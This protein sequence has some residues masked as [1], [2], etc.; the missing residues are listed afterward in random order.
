KEADVKKIFILFSLLLSAGITFAQ[1]DPGIH[2]DIQIQSTKTIWGTDS[3]FDQLFGRANLQWAFEEDTTFSSLIHVR[4]YPAGFGN[5]KLIGASYFPEDTSRVATVPAV[6]RQEAPNSAIPTIQI[7]QAWIRYKFPDFDIRVG[8]MITA[9]TR[10]LHFGNYLDCQ[11]GGTF[12][13]SREGIHNA[14]EG[15]KVFGK[16][17]TRAH[18]GVGDVVGNRGFLRVYETMSFTDRFKLGLGYRVNL[19]DMVHYDFNDDELRLTNKLAL[20][21]DYHMHPDWNLFMEAGWSHRKDDGNKDPIPA[22]VSLTY[23][24][25]EGLKSYLKSKFKILDVVDVMRAEAEY[26]YDRQSYQ[27]SYQGI[28][29]DLLWNLYA[30]KTWL[31]RMRFQGGI[32]AAPTEKRWYNVGAGVRFTSLIN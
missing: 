12:T 14:L 22:M 25:P 18:I 32:F 4:A 16:F 13:L 10:S 2:G 30:E 17:D 7:Y 3:I 11:P 6:A 23:T 26:L 31:K 21:I 15:Y 24:L 29:M 5:E 19:F 27:N 8:R 20:A 9:N 1:E 28:D